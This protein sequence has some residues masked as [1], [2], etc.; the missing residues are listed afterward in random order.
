MSVQ[1]RLDSKHSKESCTGG[2]LV[3]GEVNKY[4]LVVTKRP[5]LPLSGLVLWPSTG[6]PSWMDEDSFASWRLPGRMGT[7][8][9][10]YSLPTIHTFTHLGVPQYFISDCG[11]QFTG[12]VMEDICKSWV[13]DTQVH[14]KLPSTSQSYRERQLYHQDGLPLL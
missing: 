10:L 5:R 12:T 14:H 7:C 13:G 3:K 1:V 2:S 9:G 11:P 4:Q 6:L 8:E